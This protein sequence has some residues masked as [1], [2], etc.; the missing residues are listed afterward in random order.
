MTE[1]HW[2]NQQAVEDL[3]GGT[4]R[5]LLGWLIGAAWRDQQLQ[6]RFA[7]RLRELEPPRVSYRV[8]QAGVHAWTPAEQLCAVLD[9]FDGESRKGVLDKVRREMRARHPHLYRMNDDGS[10]DYTGPTAEA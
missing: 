10:I 2:A 8:V 9:E 7:A 3:D 1:L 5:L 4:A 6:E